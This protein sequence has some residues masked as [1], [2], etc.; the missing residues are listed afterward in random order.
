VGFR[1]SLEYVVRHLK[2]VTPKE[3][4]AVD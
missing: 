1:D 4:Q 3:T 2:E